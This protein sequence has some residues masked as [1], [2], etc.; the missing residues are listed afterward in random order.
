LFTST[1]ADIHTPH[2]IRQFRLGADLRRR[3]NDRSNRFCA[4]VVHGPERS[5]IGLILAELPL[6]EIG[7]ICTAQHL[8]WSKAYAGR[9]GKEKSL[10]K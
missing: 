2:R 1:E 6:P 4:S 8:P 7:H 9:L 10:S 3:S 5:F